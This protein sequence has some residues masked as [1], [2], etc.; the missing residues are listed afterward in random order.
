MS[1]QICAFDEVETFLVHAPVHVLS[2]RDPATARPLPLNGR[3]DVSE[4][5][6]HDRIALEPGIDLPRM[7]HVDAIIALGRRH[8]PRGTVLVHCTMGI[9]RSAAAAA[10]MLAAHE[11][12]RS[13]TAIFDQILSIRP[14]A[15]PSSLLITLADQRL[16]R[17][18]RLIEALE[19]FHTRQVQAAPE[20]AAIIARSGRAAEVAAAK[21]RAGVRNVP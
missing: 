18:G 2:I 15:W 1:I 9:S 6:F 12:A 19:A 13:E 10:I 8:L 4:L 16:N 21:T 11:P 17:G 20:T 7:E 3:N 14:I 5:E